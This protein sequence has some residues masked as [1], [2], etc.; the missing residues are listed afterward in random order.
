MTVEPEASV[1]ELVVGPDELGTVSGA[2]ELLAG[3]VLGASANVVAAFG[4]ECSSAGT[5]RG[6]SPACG[7]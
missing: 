4:T 5:A 3:G 7:G 1:G 2:F 6:R